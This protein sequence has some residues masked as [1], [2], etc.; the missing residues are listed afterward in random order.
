MYDLELKRLVTL[1]RKN[2]AKLVVIQLPDGLKPRAKEI[3]EA[4]KETTDAKILFW[5]DSCFGACDIPDLRSIKPDLFVQ[6]GHSK[7]K[8]K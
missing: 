5:G 2:K 6:F 4:I 3:Q 1:I 7:F 8:S